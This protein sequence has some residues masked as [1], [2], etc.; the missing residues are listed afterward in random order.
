MRATYSPVI[1]RTVALKSADIH[2]RHS[3]FISKELGAFFE[4][5]GFNAFTV[6]DRPFQTIALTFIPCTASEVTGT[7][8][9]DNW[10]I[11]S[12]VPFFIHGFFHVTVSMTTG[13]ALNVSFAR[14]QT[15][16]EQY[17]QFLVEVVATVD[18]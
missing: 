8:S 12:P 13:R 10:R 3:K 9:L 5:R 15:T 7:Q 1:R 18:D 2:S 16:I 17:T 11:L 6:A 14:I 4:R